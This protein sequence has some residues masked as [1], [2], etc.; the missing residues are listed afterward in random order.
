MGFARAAAKRVI[1]MDEGEIIEE[2]SPEKLFDNP[3]ME[4]TKRFL[5]HIL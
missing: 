1:F 5:E 4:R 2:G 3:D